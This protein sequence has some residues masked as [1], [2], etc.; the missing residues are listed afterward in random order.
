VVTG[1]RRVA[2]LEE[3]ASGK[4]HVVAEGGVV[5]GVTFKAIAADRVKLLVGSRTSE[6]RL[7]TSTAWPNG[8]VQAEPASLTLGAS[9]D[10]SRKAYVEPEAP[11]PSAASIDVGRLVE[12]GQPVPNPR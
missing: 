9:A 2:F 12:L 4:F 7:D 3:L 8:A 5:G 6:L 1:N 11:E 10:A